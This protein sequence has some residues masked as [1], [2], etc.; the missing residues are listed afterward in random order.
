MSDARWETK[1]LHEIARITMGQSPPSETVSDAFDSPDVPFLQ[2]NAEFGVKFPNPRYT[3]SRPLRTCEDGDTLISVRAPVGATNRADRTYCIGRGLASISFGAIDR[4][5]GWHYVTR[6]ASG[7]RSVAQGT[8]FE[9]IGK[10]EL[11]SLQISF[12]A[13]VVQKRIAQILSAADDAITSTELLIAKQRALK[14]Q[15]ACDLFTGMKRFEDTTLEGPQF[16]NNWHYGRL[17]GV[18]TIPHGWRLV[19]LVEYA[20]LESGHTP[21]RDVPSYWDG[22]VPWL[23]LHDTSKLDRHVIKATRYSVT[24]EGINNSSARLLPTGT[25]AFSRTATVGKCVILGQAMA[26]SQDF[27]CY[28]CGPEVI[29]RYLLHLFRFMQSVW[30]SLASGSTHQTVYM[31]IFENLQILLPPVVEQRRIADALDAFDAVLDSMSLVERKQRVIKQG[32]MDDLLTGR[33]QVGVS[34]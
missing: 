16:A 5:Y 27:A 7:L 22:E 11:G 32:L 4:G 33:M 1:D 23:S 26:T 25:V 2:G 18:N 9:A 17:P 14:A 3:C 30:H 20:K 19:R 21:S 24:M 34:A 31:P 13:Q 6:A 28:I 29:N 8:T 15:V 10:R 12:P